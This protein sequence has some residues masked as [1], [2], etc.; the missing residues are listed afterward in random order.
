MDCFHAEQ[1]SILHDGSAVLDVGGNRI[2]KR[3]Q[4]NIENYDLRVTYANLTTAKGPD[5][6]SDAAWLPFVDES[7]DA[8]VC[9]ELLEHVPDPPSVLKEAFRVLRRGG[10]ILICVPFIYQIHGDPYDFGRYTDYYWLNHLGK[11]GFTNIVIKKQGLFWSVL[12]DMV[13]A[14]LYD[15]DKAGTLRFR[16]TAVAM[17]ARSKKMAVERDARSESMVHPFYS[18]F[19]TGFGIVAGK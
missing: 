10:V 6:Q 19:T 1:A 17:M 4:F 7:F 13:R 16:K 18:S 3:G 12:T 5:V 14:W 15:L 11:I 2:K 9:S 8:V